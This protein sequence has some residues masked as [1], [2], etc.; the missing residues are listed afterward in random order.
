MNDYEKNYGEA[1]AATAQNVVNR[2][3]VI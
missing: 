3:R 2:R 1:A